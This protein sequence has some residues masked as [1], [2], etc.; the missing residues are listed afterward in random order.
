[1]KN[2]ASAVPELYN[3]PDITPRSKWFNHPRWHQ[4]SQMPPFHVHFRVEL[5]SVIQ[6]LHRA[7]QMVT[8]G[9]DNTK[10]AKQMI[11]S[12]SSTFRGSM[13]GLNGHVRIEEYACFPLYKENF[14]KADISFLYKDHEH[15]H[16]SEQD[17]YRAFD[18]LLKGE[19]TFNNEDALLSALNRLLDFD[20]ELIAHLGEE[21]ELVVPMSLTEKEIWF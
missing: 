19:A 9:D 12:A 11:Q 3:N 20:A 17:V 10:M 4:N 13:S 15:L 2:L 5:Q 7:Y 6:S 21:E 1:M 8:K 14:P 16:E 18:E